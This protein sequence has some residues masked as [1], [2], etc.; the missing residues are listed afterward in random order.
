MQYKRCPY[1]GLESDPTVMFTEPTRRHRCYAGRRSQQ[2]DLS[3]QATFCFTSDFEACS[4]FVPLPEGPPAARSRPRRPHGPSGGSQRL[5]LV[6]W[7]TWVALAVALAVYAYQAGVVS[8]LIHRAEAP[9][10]AATPSPLAEALPTETPTATPLPSTP[11][12]APPAA[13]LAPGSVQVML[14][15][16]ANGVGWVSTGEGSHRFG[17]GDI[18]VGVLDGEVFLGAMQFSLASIPV[19]SKIE[20]ATVELMG[21][22]GQ[23]LDPEGSGAWGVR[24]LTPDVDENWASATYDQI[25][26]AR[27]AHTLA[28]LLGAGD[29]AERKVNV[30][31][32]DLAQLR[33]L[34]R[35]LERGLVSFRLDGPRQGVDSLF[36]WDTGY[37]GG[38]VTWPV[39]RVIY[40]P[41]PTPT[42]APTDLTTATPL[43]TPTPSPTPTATPAM[44]DLDDEALLRALPRVTPT[45]TP[46]GYPQDI[47]GKIAF[48]SDRLGEDRLFAMGSDG[49]A[50]ALL[51]N[52]W[53]YETALL[54]Q[55]RSS[56]GGR[57]A[58]AGWRRNLSD[59]FLVDRA[60]STTVQITEMISGTCRDPAWSPD[61]QRIAFA[62]SRD[63]DDDLF[64][65]LSTG[66]PARQ[67][68]VN[69]SASDGHPT[70]SPDGTQ[71]AYG[72]LSLDGHRQIWVVNLDGTGLRSIS[73]GDANDWD[74]VWIRPVLTSTPVP[75]TPVPSPPPPTRAS[76]PSPTA[77]P[78]PPPSEVTIT[79][80]SK[81]SMQTGLKHDDIVIYGSGFQEGLTVLLRGEG[82]GDI[83]PY[84][85]LLTDQS[86]IGCKF[87]L[88]GMQVAHTEQWALWVMN[89][90]GGSAQTDFWVSTPSEPVSP[91][92]P[93]H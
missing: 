18:Q 12:P 37:S 74:P 29:L 23:Y 57:L 33:E 7:V 87:D 38:F 69:V 2:I 66:G 15:P 54:A 3:H 39:L 61:D 86:V 32:F 8:S 43:P 68:T 56:D 20:Y 55:T 42:S 85:V 90:D 82:R 79:G 52:E 11:T 47:L 88:T 17:G 51:T 65:V 1:V 70:W 78:I 22:D 36:I 40:Q 83:L 60:A 9:P 91:G 45:P 35:R 58:Q 76:A 5:R 16:L 93:Q 10:A 27:V 64:V 63:G 25:H 14:V 24:L 21:L 44:G 46:T 6:A 53:A 13:T 72:S 81:R 31:T 73:D 19:G 34:E 77:T 50:V 89:P 48:R 59:V 28:P 71:L 67:L 92:P 75:P 30:F 49:S 62:S 41:P 84:E 4:R 26:G 80:V